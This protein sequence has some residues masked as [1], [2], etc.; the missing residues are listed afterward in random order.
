MAFAPGGNNND[1]NNLCT[2]LG[3]SEDDL[4]TLH[5]QR[6]IDDQIEQLT[7]FG[8]TAMQILQATVNAKIDGYEPN[9]RGFM[10]RCLNH[11]ENMEPPHRQR[12]IYHQTILT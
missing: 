12:Y 1:N 8:H 9:N 5:E 11:L 6:L 4:Q 7:L 2:K 10:N 3:I